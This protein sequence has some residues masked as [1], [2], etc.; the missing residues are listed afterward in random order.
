MKK[1]W[2][3]LL[4]AMLVFMVG[5]VSV[6]AADSDPTRTPGTSAANSFCVW[7][8]ENHDG[9]CDNYNAKDTS[10]RSAQNNGS[11]YCFFDTDKDGIC[12][13][14]ED[15]SHA[16]HGAGCGNGCGGNGFHRGHVR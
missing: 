5:A 16:G 10:G 7:A 14:Y 11:G 8:D 2:C 6:F 15:G 9:I 3:I 13:R 12:D 1:L 4:S